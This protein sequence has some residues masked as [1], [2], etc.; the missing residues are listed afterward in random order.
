MIQLNRIMKLVL[1]QQRN[2]KQGV[3]ELSPL[4]IKENDEII[5]NKGNKILNL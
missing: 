3:I 4:N 5:K 2:A 1:I